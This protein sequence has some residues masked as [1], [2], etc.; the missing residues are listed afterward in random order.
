MLRDNLF[1]SIIFRYISSIIHVFTSTNIKH[2]IEN[3]VLS[4]Y[5]LYLH[6]RLASSK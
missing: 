4:V 3:V 6:I 1:I 2:C 5:I